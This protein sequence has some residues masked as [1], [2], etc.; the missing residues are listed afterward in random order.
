LLIPVVGTGHYVELTWGINAFGLFLA[1]ALV[2]IEWLARPARD[3]SHPVS[4]TS[5][6]KAT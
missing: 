4:V 3:E 2:S 6:G 1:I 5:E